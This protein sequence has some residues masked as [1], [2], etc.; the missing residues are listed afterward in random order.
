MRDQAL[1]DLATG[2]KL[3]GYDVIKLKIRDAMSE[4]SI[5]NRA[6]VVQQKP[7]APYNVN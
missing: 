7:D 5:R 6:T 2:S 3:R 1:F 4:G